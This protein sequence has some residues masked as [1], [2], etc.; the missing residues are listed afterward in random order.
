[1]ED[2]YFEVL[3]FFMITRSPHEDDSDDVAL[4]GEKGRT[5]KK[6]SRDFH[7]KMIGKKHPRA[8]PS[9]MRFSREGYISTSYGVSQ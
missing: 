1:M 9:A 6:Q 7:F 2:D 8:G 5:F 4:F 3:V